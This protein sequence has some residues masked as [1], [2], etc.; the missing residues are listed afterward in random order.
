MEGGNS[1]FVTDQ[2]SVLISALLCKPQYGS[3]LSGR[4]QTVPQEDGAK[5]KA[6]PF[7]LQ[8]R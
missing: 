4:W 2:D 1:E 5:T 7:V 8:K 6:Y 3:L